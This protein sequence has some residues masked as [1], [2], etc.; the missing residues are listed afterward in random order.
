[1]E[2]SFDR[3]AQ[4]NDE[5]DEL[6][7]RLLEDLEAVQKHLMTIDKANKML[8]DS[9]EEFGITG[10]RVTRMINMVKTDY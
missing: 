4:E 1:M 7:H 9:L 2:W 5:V 3:I 6:N 10:E 8:K